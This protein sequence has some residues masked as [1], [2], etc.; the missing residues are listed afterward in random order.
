MGAPADPWLAAARR[1]A[2]E[3][4]GPRKQALMA[5][6]F[7][8]FFVEAL[9]GVDK[10]VGRGTQDDA[11]APPGGVPAAAAAPGKA[12]GSPGPLSPGAGAAAF[13]SHRQR[14]RHGA[15]GSGGGGGGGAGAAL[16]VT[17]SEN[18]GHGGLS[19]SSS[20]GRATAAS[21]GAANLSINAEGLVGHHERRTS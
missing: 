15:G 21:G 13:A 1:V 4:W 16:G 9:S 10:Y 7:L 5:R 18:L 8:E 19:G 17:Q 12:P 6:L 11:A 2:P 3:G 20:F 14:S